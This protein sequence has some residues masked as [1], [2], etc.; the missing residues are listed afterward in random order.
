VL[1]D[2][3]AVGVG[4]GGRPVAAAGVRQLGALVDVAAVAP[5]ARERVPGRALAPE[6]AHR[7]AAPPVAAHHAALAA[8]VYI[9]THPRILNIPGYSLK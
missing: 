8:L 4:A 9:C 5:V 2:V 6:R 3:P 7:V 1:G